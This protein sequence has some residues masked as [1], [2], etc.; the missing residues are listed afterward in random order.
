M[1][2]QVKVKICGNT[3]KEDVEH[4][5]ISGADAIGFIVGFPS[6]PRNLDLDK[7]EQLMKDIP[8]SIE[9]KNINNSQGDI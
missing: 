6:T 7:A 2:R 9:F 4:A 5:I 3:R 1:T 8:K